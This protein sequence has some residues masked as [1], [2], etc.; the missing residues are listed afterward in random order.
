VLPAV[1][2]GGPS[3][4][5]QQWYAEMSHS[6]ELA[7][8]VPVW[9]AQ[10]RDLAPEAMLAWAAE[11]FGPRVAFATSL[12]AEDQVLTE[13]I[14]RRQFAIPLFTLD[15]GRLFQETYE[16][17]QQTEARYGV[18]IRIMFP[19]A[20]AVERMVTEH[21]INL[22][23]ESVE[24]RRK[25]CGIRKIEPLRRAFAG[26]DAWVCGLRRDQSVTRTDLQPVEWDAANGLV[27][28]SP[29]HDWTN[30]Q[31]WAY[32]KQHDVPYN[33]L[34]DKGFLSIGCACCTR[35]VKPGEDIRAGRWWWETPDKKE[36]G[37]HFKDGKVVRGP[38]PG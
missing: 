10:A 26:L 20:A 15:T 22:F 27:K 24:L 3:L 1:S 5:S 37:L 31:V 14:G 34:H 23:R 6:P 38:Q 32:L 11:T 13:M 18:R 35:A 25:C 2:P 21:G 36:C 12:G 16:L 33:P 19:E 4:E 28:I 8:R 30:D 17:L 29:L 7:A 9:L